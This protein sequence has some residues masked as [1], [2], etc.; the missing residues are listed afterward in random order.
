V[1]APTVTPPSHVVTP[2]ARVVPVPVPVPVPNAPPTPSRGWAPATLE[3]A[4]GMVGV[5]GRDLS[6]VEIGDCDVAVSEFRR[7]TKTA[8]FVERAKEHNTYCT[9][10]NLPLPRTVHGFHDAWRRENDYR[11]DHSE[12]S[13]TYVERLNLSKPDFRVPKEVSA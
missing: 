9:A 6:Q 2:R 10:K 8:D 5:L 7:L 1:T 12:S 3:L 4:Q 13:R 11:A